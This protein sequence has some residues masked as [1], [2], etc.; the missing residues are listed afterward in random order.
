VTSETRSAPD[1]SPQSHPQPS[2]TPKIAILAPTANGQAIAQQL[3]QA[4][5]TA[6]LLT[7]T[8]D[9][10]L[11]DYLPDIWRHYDQFI[12]ILTTGAVVRL[13]APLLR[14]KTWDPGVV[15]IDE[16]GQFVISLSGGHRG[17]ADALARQVAALLNVSPIITAGSTRQRVPAVDLLGLPYGWVAGSGNW[18]A[19]ASALT[20]GQTV[21]L[22]QTAGRSDLWSGYRFPPQ[23]FIQNFAPSTTT[24]DLAVAD[25]GTQPVTQPVANT[26]SVTN[27]VT[28][29]IASSISSSITGNC[30]IAAMIAITDRQT[31]TPNLKTLNTLNTPTVYWHPRTLWI[32]V[33]CERGTA[34]ALIETAIT[35]TL[36]ETGWAIAAVAGIAS[37]TLKQDEVGILDV[38]ARHGWALRWFDAETLN[39]IAVPNPSEIV[40][41]AVGTPSVAEAAAIAAAQQMTRVTRETL[42]HTTQNVDKADQSVTNGSELVLEKRIFR[43]DRGACTIAVARSAVE[44]N[45]NPGKLFLIGTGPGDLAQITP[46][47]RAAIAQC[48]TLIGYGLYLD[49][50][51]ALVHPDQRVEASPIGQEVQRAQRAIELVQSGLTVGVVSSGDC[52][53]YAMA[54]LVLECLAD[55]G[56]DGVT[57]EVEILPGISALQAIAA[58][59][60]AP[61]MH[62]FCTISL[63]DLLT[64]WATI[65]QRLTAAA[66]GDFVTI[67]YNP[68]S[69]QRLTQLATAIEIFRQYRSPDTPV[70]I[71]R[72]LYRPDEVI[73]VMRLGEFEP[74]MV[75]M[76]TTVLIGNSA[77]FLCGDRIITPRGYRVN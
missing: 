72:S 76:L 38:A 10:R 47:A 75:D 32:G 54:G 14:D 29:S 67:F 41:Q 52:G 39:T 74:E 23:V 28:H 53:I 5:D 12:F 4:L 20:Q 11:V 43:D 57:P 64:P 36:A 6:E 25:S 27:L 33:G 13:I 60:G 48:H 40:T 35:Q 77:T 22:I 34:A 51:E 58:R 21:R 50:L 46:A 18:L 24:Y 66:T 9:A 61:L 71:G 19:V 3:T 49:L 65:L 59:V 45:P 8:S 30:E 56:W 42:N 69:R 15:T 44:F 68:R 1:F 37:I 16:T 55:R 2:S 63:S 73:Q 62:D 26:D 31:L 7:G 70:A 17:G